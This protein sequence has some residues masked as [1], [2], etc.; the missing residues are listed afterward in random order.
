M[1]VVVV[2]AVAIGVWHWFSTRPEVSAAC[3]MAMQAAEREANESDTALLATLDACETADSWIAALQA[4]PGAGVLI[5]YTRGDAIESLDSYCV[6]RVDAP[7]CVDAAASGML[8][9]EL[10]DTRLDELQ[11]PR[12]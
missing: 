11:V 8:T 1:S 7:V 4:H 5:E 6:R 12:G 10:D 3:T 2:V 9:Y